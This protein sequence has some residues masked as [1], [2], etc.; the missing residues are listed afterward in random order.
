MGFRSGGRRD[1]LSLSFQPVWLQ[2]QRKKETSAN[3]LGPPG[4]SINEK[5]SAT[6]P[7]RLGSLP[8]RLCTPWTQQLFHRIVEHGWLFGSGG[9]SSPSAR[10]E[11]HTVAGRRRTEALKAPLHER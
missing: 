11:P 6:D 5:I 9:P 4:L 10:G 7:T 8:Q 1:Q 3:L 2:R